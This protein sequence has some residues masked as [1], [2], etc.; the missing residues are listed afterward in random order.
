MPELLPLILLRMFHVP[1]MVFIPIFVGILLLLVGIKDFQEDE[2]NTR[3][4]RLKNL[5][6]EIGKSAF[7]M[8][9]SV[10]IWLVFY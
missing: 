10:F 2:E 8:L 1:L 7:F 5:Y 4:T 9:L 3:K 6:K